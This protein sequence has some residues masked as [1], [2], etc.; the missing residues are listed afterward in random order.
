MET[1]TNMLEKDIQLA[2]ELKH[3]KSG[4]EKKLLTWKDIY[5]QLGPNEAAVEIIRIQEFKPDSGGV[6]TKEVY[7]AAL[8]ITKETKNGPQ[9]VLMKNGKDLETRY[10]SY[11]RNAIHFQLEDTISYQQYWKPLVESS[12]MKG[13]NKIYLS[14]DGVYN[15]ININTFYN[16]ATKKYVVQE[17]DVQLVTNT[18]DVVTIK[19]K[20]TLLTKIPENTV[21]F[22]YPD[23]YHQPLMTAKNVNKKQAT[24]KTSH[25]LFRGG[26][27][28]ELPGT[29]DEVNA[30]NNIFV[31][32]GNNTTT[33]MLGKNA[34][35]DSLKAIENPGILHI[36][37]HGF[38]LESEK[39]NKSEHKDEVE[40]L[41][42]LNDNP[43]LLCGIMLSGAGHAYSEEVL[44]A[45]IKALYKGESMED[46]ILTAYEAMNMD[47]QN[48]ELVV[49]SCCETGLG[50]VKNGEGVYGFQRALQT[51]GAKTII[52]SLWKVNDAATKKLMTYFYEEWIRTSNKRASFAT[53]Q[54][55]LRLEYKTPLFWGAFIMIGE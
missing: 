26:N 32:N 8:I 20:P 38:F 33:V 50:E 10:V 21:L 28:N 51:A 19:T 44:D 49:L 6:N 2:I 18:K 43:L 35:E 42:E 37:S 16:S 48:L 13:K 29:K 39:K 46:G 12:V 9:L 55:K 22:G 15:Q 53:A 47:L 11:Y 54:E 36:A 23:Y 17:Q 14:V 30:I 4:E 1:L 24:E 31:T 41:N 25:T 52:Q 45:E 5:A 27:I 34:A 7:Y 40:V 3:S